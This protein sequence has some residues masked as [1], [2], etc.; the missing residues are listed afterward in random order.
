VAVSSTTGAG[1]WNE[2]WNGLFEHKTVYICY[3]ADE[4]GLKGS[5]KVGSRLREHARL[6]KIIRHDGS[7]GK[8]VT[9]WLKSSGHIPFLELIKRPCFTWLDPPA[10][11]PPPRV[12]RTSSGGSKE[13]ILDV[14]ER[15]G[16]V[17][18]KV[19][20]EFV[21]KSPFRSESQA[22]FSVNVEKQCWYDYGEGS[23]GG[24]N[25]LKERLGL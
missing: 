2:A 19:G 7:L 5:L 8:D 15:A 18:R 10:Y 14:C 11:E 4:A 6:V 20:R 23:G 21:G 9:E 12:V 22:S 17:L 25:S 1:N 3:D 24:V 16:I 13:S